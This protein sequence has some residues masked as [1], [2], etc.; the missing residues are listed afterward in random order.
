MKLATSVGARRW[1]AHICHTLHEHN[2][3]TGFTR[4]L[5]SNKDPY[6]HP[7]PS[8]LC[9]RLTLSLG[10]A[11]S[12]LAALA[13]PAMNKDMPRMPPAEALSA[14]QAAKPG[15]DCSF[16]SPQ[17]QVKGTCWAPEG[18]PLACKPATPPEGRM[19]PKQ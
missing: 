4:G 9:A 12:G 17:G 8:M 13:Q 6:A 3:R 1:L 10:L 15:Q 18:K 19:P 2:G 14:C 11:L 16:D 5:L 7:I